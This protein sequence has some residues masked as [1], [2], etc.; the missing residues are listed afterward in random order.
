[1]VFLAC[2]NDF[3]GSIGPFA[4]GT[5]GRGIGLRCRWLT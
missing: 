2:L 1:M 3:A 4:V 5:G